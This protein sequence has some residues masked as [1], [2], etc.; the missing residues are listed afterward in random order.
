MASVRQGV[1]LAVV[2]LIFL[3]VESRAK[4]TDETPANPSVTPAEA[5]TPKK[6]PPLHDGAA[7]LFA[8]ELKITLERYLFG[9]CPQTFKSR[10]SQMIGRGKNNATNSCDLD[11]EQEDLAGRFATLA[12]RAHSAARVDCARFGAA[13]ANTLGELARTAANR[14]ATNVANNEANKKRKL[15][16][17]QKAKIQAKQ[18]TALAVK[19]KAAAAAAAAAAKMASA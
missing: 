7:L 11:T 17:S 9:I 16:K 3:C 19:K 18:R 6:I 13:L 14:H 5:K 2:L 8:D 10:W 15:S 1:R 4:L 12:L